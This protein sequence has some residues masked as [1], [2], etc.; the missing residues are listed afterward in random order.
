MKNKQYILFILIVFSIYSL[1]N[2][3]IF[4]RGL[5]AIPQESAL[6]PVYYILFGILSLSYISGRL[7]EKV[8]ISPISF[9]LTWIGSFWL[10]AMIYSFLILIILDFARLLNLLFAIFPQFIEENYP[11]IKLAL[12]TSSICL[13]LLLIAGGHINSLYIRSK[14][15]TLN[16]NKKT[17]K[18][19]SL[20][21]VVISDI[22]LG[23]IIGPKRLGNLIKKVN[24]LN[25]DL[26]LLAG[27]VV[28]EDLRS[29]FHKNIGNQL[30]NIKSQL[31]IY[32]ITGNHEY[33]GGVNK[34][35]R[36]L[37]DHKINVLRDD[38]DLVENEIYIAGREDRDRIR[39]TGKNRKSLKN[40]LSGVDK[41]K[42][43]ILLDHQ[44]LNLIEA[45]KNQVDLQISGHTHN[46]QIWPL[47]LIINRI[48]EL[49][50]GY[51]KKGNT[52]YY[53]SSGFG[54][55]GPP[56]RIGTQSEIVQII[57]K[58]K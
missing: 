5:Q 18:W 20:N 48:Y 21:L 15:I 45:E 24:E 7:L 19:K 32:A 46:G 12:F 39:F 51:K 55:W 16:I 31:G 10:A 30:I 6:K 9:C 36:Y 57:L 50:T 4:I 33:I 49:S 53:V 23:S 27:D 2:I 42:P 26:V 25:P 56:V 22:H 35:T 47:N 41:S 28:D 58:F 52:H 3:Y 54:T 14:K 44:P 17:G 38:I 37:S 40:I 11:A 34:A 13:I 1:F 8:W 43:I 29:V